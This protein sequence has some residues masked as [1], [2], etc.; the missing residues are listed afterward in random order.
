[1]STASK[2]HAQGRAEGRAELLE[3]L[4]TERFGPLATDVRARIRNT[5]IA[6]LDRC[7]KNLLRAR[8]LDE[9]FDA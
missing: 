5:S 9:V 4:L 3:F 7:A 8:H 2:L 1:M 6:E